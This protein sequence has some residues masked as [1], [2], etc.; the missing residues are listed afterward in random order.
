MSGCIPV[1]FLLFLRVFRKRYLGTPMPSAKCSYIGDV[2]PGWRPKDTD[3]WRREVEFPRGSRHKRADRAA[4]LQGAPLT[5]N[6]KHVVPVEDAGRRRAGHEEAGFPAPAP[7]SGSSHPPSTPF[8]KCHF[9]RK[10]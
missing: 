1:A 6:L 3:P 2:S 4:Q 9:K 5:I 10:A 8:I 7:P